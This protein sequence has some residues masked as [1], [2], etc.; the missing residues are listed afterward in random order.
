MPNYLEL[1]LLAAQRGDKEKAI[2]NLSKYV[3]ENPKSEDGWLRLGDCLTDL[4]KRSYC[5]HRVIAINPQHQEARQKLAQLEQPVS[6]AY[7]LDGLGKVEI[8]SPRLNQQTKKQPQNEPRSMGNFTLLGIAGLI[9]A[10]VIIGI[11]LIYLLL[12]LPPRFA[13]SAPIAIASNSS[14]PQQTNTVPPTYTPTITPTITS[15]PDLSRMAGPLVAQA[16]SLATQGN[17]AEAIQT[18]NQALIYAPNSDKAYYLRASSYH[19]LLAHDRVLGEYQDYVSAGL[20]DI[21]SAIAIE[22]N[23]GDYYSLREELLISLLSIMDYRADRIHLNNY[24][25]DN[26][27]AAINLA[28]TLQDYPERIYASDMIFA[29]R[30]DEAVQFLQELISKTDPK[31][32]SIGGLYHL[33]SRS[34]ICLGDID[35]AIFLIKK[36]MF[37]NTNMD[38]KNE[39]LAT[40]LF[41]AGQEEQA[42]K[43]MNDLLKENPYYGGER[44]Y[45]RAAINYKLGNSEQ[46]ET[47]LETGAENTWFHAGLYSYVLGKVAL[48]DGRAED[49]IQLLQNAEATLDVLYTPLRKEISNDLKELGAAPLVVT[50]SVMTEATSIPTILPRPTARQLVITPTT[51]SYISDTTPI[52]GL[53]YPPS[54]DNGII[55]DPQK[56]TGPII[57]RADD[58]PMFRLQPSEPYEI[59]TVKNVVINLAPF[60]TEIDNPTLQIS[61]YA[62]TGGW[63][64]LDPAWGENPVLAPQDVVYP[65]GEMVIAVRNYGSSPVS[66]GNLSVTIIFESKD[67]KIIELGPG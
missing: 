49:G 9:G 10:I 64:F 27:I 12:K 55:F 35:K 36:S 44:Y 28:A 4:E 65:T 59:K 57:L 32:D 20:K 46:A 67:G 19:S 52:A 26:D 60:S 37:N 14:T 43:L 15:T 13:L 53:N 21:D 38:M 42:L 25:I 11:P 40:Y 50:P 7:G 22:P 61:M 48:D 30:C 24:A 29:E 23:I 3:L 34:Y 2:S 47:D 66:V 41:Q 6:E 62:Y 56:G 39:L 63:K 5:Y 18:L 51:S 16:E 1:G 54:I 17:Y 33:Q 31:D 45:L 58:F 8:S